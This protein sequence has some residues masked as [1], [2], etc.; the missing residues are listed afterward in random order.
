[1]DN[2]RKGNLGEYISL[3]VGSALDFTSVLQIFAH[4]AV[5]PLQPIS[6]AGIDICYA[7]FDEV[8]PKNDILWIQETK[9]TSAK[10]IALAD[11]LV[12]DYEKLFGTDLNRTLHSRIQV[13]QNRLEVERKQPALSSRLGALAGTTPAQCVNIRL[14]P[15]L[16]HD[17]ASN[18]PVVKLVAVRS[19]ICSFGWSQSQ[20]DGWS[21]PFVA[22][23]DVLG[24]LATGA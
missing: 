1:M 23:D 13:M 15:T 6:A 24:R 18:D 17:K 11:H 20:I 9:T 3:H 4:N 7:L 5:A 2:R 14:I 19:S 10:D 16:V 8:N 12:E 22:L 21:V